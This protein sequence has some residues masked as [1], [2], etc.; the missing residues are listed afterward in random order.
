M[1]DT[2]KNTRGILLM[3]LSMASFAVGD[4]AFL[5]PAQTMFI[6]ISSGLII[7]AVIALAKG[8]KKDALRGMW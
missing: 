2:H 3:L 4:I 6:L 8:E 7:F 5:S 1:M